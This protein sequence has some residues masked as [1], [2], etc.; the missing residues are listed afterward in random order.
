MA[1]PFKSEGFWGPLFRRRDRAR[2]V[3]VPRA[4][5]PSKRQLVLHLKAKADRIF[6][7][8]RLIFD[9][10]EPRVLLNADITTTWTV[11]SDPNVQ[12]HQLL[13][14]LVEQNEGAGQSATK[15]QRI[16]VYDYTNGQQGATALQTFGPI[17]NTNQIFTITGTS[18]KD[19]ITVD[20]ESFKPLTGTGKPTLA[21]SDANAGDGDA[22]TLLNTPT[23]AAQKGAA[24]ALI[25]ADAGSIASGNFK[26]TFTSV[27]DLAGAA[28]AD[29]TLTVGLGASLSGTFG[30]KE[31]C[32][33]TFRRW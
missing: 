23:D 33:S 19:V 13:V 26:G 24:F 16:Q 28:G 15:V 6:N 32:S 5:R 10:L 17:D 3:D 11:P 30:S 31:A 14:K 20:V 4:G 22:I 2:S 21:F 1:F 29:D 27:G 9:P 8:D 25:G 18:K 7:R 12:E